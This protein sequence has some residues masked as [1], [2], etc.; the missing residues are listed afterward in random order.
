MGELPHDYWDKEREKLLRE[1]DI[2]ILKII[3]NCANL[4]KLKK[5]QKRAGAWMPKKNRNK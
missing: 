3:E 2:K 1:E 5:K 4:P